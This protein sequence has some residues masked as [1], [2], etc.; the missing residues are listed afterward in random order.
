MECR[1]KYCFCLGFTSLSFVICIEYSHQSQ[2]YGLPRL[3][4]DL[5]IWLTVAL[6]TELRGQRSMQQPLHEYKEEKTLAA[7][8]ASRPL[9]KKTWIFFFFNNNFNN[10]IF[11]QVNPS[12]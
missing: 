2:W 5:R 10:R 6:P 3:T 12:V 7:I 9:R 4:H 11:L 8:Y 1:K